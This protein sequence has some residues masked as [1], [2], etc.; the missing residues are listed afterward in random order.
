MKS[1]TSRLTFQPDKH[2]SSVRLQQ[3]R[4]QL[5]ADWNEQ[6]DIQSWLERTLV[7]DAIG[8]SG[9]PKGE[10]FKIDS[11]ALPFDLLLA[12]GRIWIDGLLCELG[13]EAV[14]ATFPGPPK[15]LAAPAR[16]VLSGQPLAVGQWVSVSGG[17][18]TKRYR[19]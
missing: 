1:D 17:G 5:D 15:N 8:Q 18:K 3:G 19:I 9:V 2:Y 13:D 10:G 4:V 12:P 16:L 7:R 11:T 6:I 14:P